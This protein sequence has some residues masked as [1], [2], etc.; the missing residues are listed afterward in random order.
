M[1]GKQIV[2]LDTER[3]PNLFNPRRITSPAEIDSLFWHSDRLPFLVHDPSIFTR[4]FAGGGETGT[5]HAYIRRGAE[6]DFA[7]LNDCL[8]FVAQQTIIPMLGDLI[9]QTSWGSSLANL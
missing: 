7:V 3:P 1:T 4:L 9:P 5:K 8:P 2:R 6:I